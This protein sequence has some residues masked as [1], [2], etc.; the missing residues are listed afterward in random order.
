M[1]RRMDPRKPAA[2]FFKV[3]GLVLDDL[4]PGDSAK[5]VELETRWAAVI[6]GLAIL[7]PLHEQSRRL[8]SVLAEAQ[9]S[10][11]RFARLIRGDA[12]RLVEELPALARF[13]AAKGAPVDWSWAAQLILSAGREDE[14]PVRRNVARDYFG[15]LARLGR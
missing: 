1:L 14:E 9:F 8:G 12:D 2:A 11:L 7:G 13:L 6:A 4:L 5:R 15:A 10:E 3:E